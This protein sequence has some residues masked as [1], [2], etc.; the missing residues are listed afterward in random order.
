MAP[1]DHQEPRPRAAR[2]ASRYTRSSCGPVAGPNARPAGSARS[3]R[4]ASRLH[5]ARRPAPRF[6]A[7]S[8]DRQDDRAGLQVHFLYVV[9]RDGVD[10]GLDT[11]SA[12][13]NS[14]GSWQEWL[15]GQTG[16]RQLYVDTSVGLEARRRASL[17]SGCATHDASRSLARGARTSRAG[18]S[19]LEIAVELR[20]RSAT[21]PSRDRCGRCPRTERRPDAVR[22]RLK[23]SMKTPAVRRTSGRRAV[24]EAARRSGARP[25][26][27]EPGSGSRRPCYF[28]PVDALA[29]RSSHVAAH[30]A[31]PAQPHGDTAATMSPTW[32]RHDLTRA[33]SRLPWLVA[34]SRKA[35]FSMPVTV[36]CYGRRPRLDCPRRQLA[37]RS[38]ER[39]ACTRY[40][41]PRAR[42]SRSA[43]AEIP[44]ADAC[45]RPHA[46]REPLP[47]DT[48]PAGTAR[49][50][51]TAS[52]A[53][54]GH[55]RAQRSAVATTASRAGPARTAHRRPPARTR[56]WSRRRRT[57]RPSQRDG[58]RDGVNCGLGRRTSPRRSRRHRS[59]QLRNGASPLAI[60]SAG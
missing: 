49:C 32:S 60:A 3:S 52:A 4:R 24:S 41:A 46:K 33:R 57:T 36:N 15:R 50:T 38:S 54:G 28:E 55:D 23:F 40:L 8:S 13:T 58:T 29:R 27:D 7:P 35:S 43:E 11:N 34:A 47:Q 22:R 56:C 59:T 42:H 53:R 5:S 14:I 19:H 12:I 1:R 18:E 10:R 39:S 17:T 2:A 20:G 26:S 51:R 44:A 31:G 30:V 16:G 37:V 25:C 21:A 9:P 45:C 48:A 6:R